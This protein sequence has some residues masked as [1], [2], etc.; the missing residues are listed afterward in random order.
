MQSSWNPCKQS[1]RPLWGL[2]LLVMTSCSTIV[3]GGPATIP[4]DSRPSDAQLT[5]TNMHTDERVVST[6]TPYKAVLKRGAGYFQSA[7]YKLAF[8]KEGYQDQEVLITGKV[9]GWYFGNLLFGGLI[10]MVIVDPLTGAMWVLR[11]DEVQ[12]ELGKPSAFFDNTDEG[13]LVVLR[14]Q[15]PALEGALREVRKITPERVRY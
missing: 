13:L 11:P 14:E 7:K 6:K 10:G 15:V 3:H 1:L 5:I 9:D 2:L 4:I 8:H 12:A